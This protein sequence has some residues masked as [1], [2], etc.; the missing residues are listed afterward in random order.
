MNK[1]L[2]I[3]FIILTSIFVFSA[4]SNDDDDAPTP[5][6]FETNGAFVINQ[7]NYY[8]TIA[9]SIGFY[10]SKAETFTDSVF[11][12]ANGIL[13]VNTLQAGLVFN[14][15]FWAIAYQS[16]VL[17]VTDGNLKLKKLLKVNAPR[18]LAASGNYVFVTN[19][20]GYVTRVNASSLTIVDSVKVGPNPE[21][22]AV[23][24]GY[25]YVTNS[26]GL[27][28]LNGY[29]N[30]FS[31]SK[32]NLSTFKVEKKIAVGMNPTKAVADSLGNVFVIAMGNYST[33]ASKIQKISK[34]DVVSDFADASIMAVNGTTLYAVNSVTNWSTYQ[35][36]STYFKIN[37]VTGVRTDNLISEGVKHPIALGVNPTDKHLF[38]TSFNDGQ[39]GS[40]YNSAGYMNEYS[41]GGSLIKT[42]ATGVNPVQLVFVRSTD[43]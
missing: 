6:L 39:W 15:K 4:C 1:K 36:V 34:E 43:F 42:F 27:N 18:A 38:I 13:P 22:M 32:I 28:Y 12:K 10:S 8:S 25:L 9:G 5:K 24:N 20:D 41:Q 7:G 23:A 2:S 30:G 21:E 11:Y 14:K 3:F 33:V 37:T 31:V 16:N 29:A 17:F 19:Y 40:D 35:T 26:D